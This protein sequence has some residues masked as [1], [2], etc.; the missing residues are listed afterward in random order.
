MPPDL[1]VLP[2][3]SSARR[4]AYSIWIWAL[5]L[6]KSS[7]AH[8]A[9]ASWTAGSRRSSTFFG[10]CGCRIGLL[11]GVLGGPVDPGGVGEREDLGGCRGGETVLLAASEV[12]V[13]Y[14]RV[15][16]HES[17][18]TAEGRV[19]GQVIVS[20][21]DEKRCRDLLA[22]TLEDLGPAIAECDRRL[23]SGGQSDTGVSVRREA[24]R[25]L[26]QGMPRLYEETYWGEGAG[27]Q[28]RRTPSIDVVAR[29]RV[30]R[31]VRRKWFITFVR[32]TWFHTHLTVNLDGTVQLGSVPATRDSFYEWIS[33]G[34]GA[35]RIPYRTLAQGD[36]DRFSGRDEGPDASELF[37]R[38][39][40]FTS[41]DVRRCESL[42]TASAR[43]LRGIM[44][45]CENLLPDWGFSLEAENPQDARG[46][47]EMIRGWDGDPRLYEE[48]YR[49][50]YN[51]KRHTPGLEV[52][53]NKSADHGSRKTTF[54]K[55]TLTVS[56]DGIVQ[57]GSVPATPDSLREWFIQC[58]SAFP[59]V[60]KYIPRE[61]E[62]R[63]PDRGD[64]MDVFRTEGS[65]SKHPGYREFERWLA[66]APF[67]S[68]AEIDAM[69]PVT[70]YGFYAAYEEV[71]KTPWLRSI[72]EIADILADPAGKIGINPGL[73]GRPTWARARID[74]T[75][76]PD[77][78]KTRDGFTLPYEDVLYH[79]VHLSK[80]QDPDNGWK[81]RD[82]TASVWRRDENT[83]VVRWKRGFE[84]DYL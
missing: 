16:F 82:W 23:K 55:T 76:P 8:L 10:S 13:I 73:I 1:R 61:E 53:I 66:R 58:M 37:R 75:A 22:A 7:A 49:E 11:G 45:D 38:Q 36:R 57:L 56:A 52:T 50:R 72:I 62:V 68:Q 64:R 47:A 33:C 77:K 28:Y 41:G 54:G 79:R 3:C 15:D 30:G 39:P 71:L 44:T 78:Y 24:W 25:D 65:K 80:H 59:S 34:K 63:A 40:M 69:A 83:V 35:A 19:A 70:Y 84:G 4:S 21:G 42:L 27:N 5:T 20:L 46:K 18:L 32:W 31:F 74:Y 48:F 67:I 6:R 51:L 14:E 60:A 17:S 43:D 81:Y 29:V 26:W 2:A 12:S 9:I